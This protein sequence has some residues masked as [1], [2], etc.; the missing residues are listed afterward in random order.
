MKWIPAY[1]TD[2][3][4]RRNINQDSLAIRVADTEYGQ[5]AMA[6]VADGMGGM[7]A[8]ELASKQVIFRFIKWF[9]KELPRL[10]YRDPLCNFMERELTKIIQE[11]NLVLCSYGEKTGKDLG[12]TATGMVFFGNKYYL[13]H[14]GDSR[15]YE[16]GKDK[17]EQISIDYSFLAR[18]V[19]EGRMTPEEA[20]VDKRKNLLTDCV[21]IQEKMDFQYLEGI[22]KSGSGYLLCSDGFW[23]KV[24]SEEMGMINQLADRN[25]DSEVISEKLKE[26]VEL[27]KTR[28]EKDNISVIYVHVLE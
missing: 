19:R 11:E 15:C 7:Q 22:V 1:H 18:E 9:E 5:I 17:M 13:I 12:T 10:L 27:I 16:I 26:Q 23:H 24:H 20:A 14:V 25:P 21:G 6:V 28:M 4:I 3:G 8:G 2:I